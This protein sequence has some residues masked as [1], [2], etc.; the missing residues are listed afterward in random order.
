MWCVCMWLGAHV[1]HCPANTQGEDREGRL[2]GHGRQPAYGGSDGRETEDFDSRS[3]APPR[4]T[5]VNLQN[6]H[7]Q[8]CCYSLTVLGNDH[9]V[10][11]EECPGQTGLHFKS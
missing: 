1:F 9:R 5:E 10:A 3:I 7:L 2:K 6:C 8:G 4:A 11:L